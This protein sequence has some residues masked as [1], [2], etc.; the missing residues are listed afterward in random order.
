MKKIQILMLAVV[1]MFAFSAVVASAASAEE[2]LPL[3][4]V[5]G[6]DVPAGGVTVDVTVSGKLLLEDMS[7]TGGA[8]DVECEGNGL[9][10]LLPEG[11]DE[12]NSANA[13][14][15]KLGTTKGQCSE[16][17]KVE[18]V[19]LPWL[20][21]LVQVGTA[22]EDNL[23]EGKSATEKPGWLVLCLTVL[24]EVDD[25]C[26]TN[27][28]KTLLTNNE[29]TGEVESEF[30]ESAAESEWAGCT[31]P[32]TTKS[33]LVVGLVLLHVLLP[34]NELMTLAASLD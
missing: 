12:Q 2:L 25:T 10:L 16:V 4:L 30:A 15:C 3:W 29:T 32:K 17:L 9:G 6:E 18:A 33:G 23:F 31:Q 19:D 28:G 22:F 8:V 20:T 1:A 7:A 24:G 34:G 11:L 5:M 26:T 14:N 27:E 21:Q 13:E